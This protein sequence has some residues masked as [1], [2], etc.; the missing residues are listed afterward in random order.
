[1]NRCYLWLCL[2]LWAWLNPSFAQEAG[3][4]NPV[5]GLT[6][7]ADNHDTY[8]TDLRTMTID[9][10]STTGSVASIK[11]YVDGSFQGNVSNPNVGTWYHDIDISPGTNC[12]YLVVRCNYPGCS[13]NGQQ[14]LTRCFTYMRPLDAGDIRVVANETDN[15]IELSWIKYTNPGTANFHYRIY[16]STTNDPTT[17]NPVSDWTTLDEYTDDAATAGVTYYYWVKTAKSQTGLDESTF[18]PSR[19]ASLSATVSLS[20][21]SGSFNADGGSTTID[22]TSN[23]N[24][25]SST[26]DAWIQ[27]T[28]NSGN[29][30][31]TM[32]SISCT[33][34]T[35]SQS[36]TGTVVFTAASS[37]RQFTITQSA[38]LASPSN[39]AF[40]N[41]LPT[42][43]DLSW[44][45]VPN[46]DSY[47]IR[48]CTTDAIIGSSSNPTFRLLNQLPGSQRSLQVR[49]LNSSDTSDYSNCLNIVFP[50][51]TTPDVRLT[52]QSSCGVSGRAHRMAV[53]GENLNNITSLQGRLSSADTASADITGL[54][55]NWADDP[56][57]FTNQTADGSVIFSWT[58]ASSS[59][60]SFLDGDTLFFV[61]LYLKGAQG[62]SIDI[63]VDTSR[64]SLEISALG[65]P[66]S[67]GLQNGTVCLLYTGSIEGNIVDPSGQGIDNIQ[68]FL[69][70]DHQANVIS[71]LSGQFLFDTL[72]LDNTYHIAP[73]KT[74]PLIDGVDVLDVIMIRRHVLEIERFTSPFQYIAAEIYKGRKSEITTLDIYNLEQAILGNILRFP[75]NKTHVFIPDDYVFADP[76]NPF[77]YDT[78]RVY[79]PLT[80]NQSSQ[81]FRAVKIGDVSGDAEFLRV[82]SGEVQIGMF[83]DTACV[84]KEYVVSVYAIGNHQ[85]EGWQWTNTWSAEKLKFVK[86]SYINETA[87][88]N[89]SIAD[90]FG[91]EQTEQGLLTFIWSNPGN[92]ALSLSDTILLY[93][94]TFQVIGEKDDSSFFSTNSDLTKASAYNTDL[95]AID[96]IDMEGKVHIN[97]TRTSLSELYGNLNLQISPNPF[98]DHVE[99]SFYNPTSEAASL[100][101]FDGAGRMIQ[102]FQS[103]EGQSEVSFRWDASVGAAGPV[104]AGGYIGLLRIGDAVESF[105]LTRVR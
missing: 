90:N 67:V 55:G 64:T 53:T 54:S 5:V 84:E 66:V 29:N 13:I 45:A 17:A 95:S 41:L 24:W 49:A 9:G 91:Q 104:A 74:S 65:L 15:Q 6:I 81:G 62:D 60:R 70:G 10:W 34:N 40:A 38:N 56:R 26:S 68:V 48:D 3:I 100:H 21:S 103:E 23:A 7:H 63:F 88:K 98:R 99:V 25:T 71:D 4:T 8:M 87:M 83:T 31:T 78:S 35:S 42:S 12:V 73:I 14:T 89:C 22:L 72:L 69:S 94:I 36:R 86:I 46:A 30:G 18:G 52:L 77:P 11:V 39:L 101:I 96:I 43:V 20:G 76:D 32:V 61:D 51:P 59:G 16:R 19:S 28:P 80:A 44:T 85:I 50:V 75:I 58:D 47:Q 92:A 93:Q 37:S 97:D 105:V 57:F 82:Q 33:P 2:L 1:M 79:N 102:S 27:V